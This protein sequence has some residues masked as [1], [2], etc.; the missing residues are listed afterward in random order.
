MY[1]R[2]GSQA[3]REQTLRERQGRARRA[4]LTFGAIGSHGST[5]YMRAI[6]FG[7]TGGFATTTQSA[8]RA[9]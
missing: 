1:L 8:M 9:G 3:E 2:L 5:I 7:T 6:E 4:G